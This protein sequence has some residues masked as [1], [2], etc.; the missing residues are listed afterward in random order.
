MKLPLVK[1]GLPIVLVY[2]GGSLVIPFLSVFLKD[3]HAAGDVLIGN[4]WAY[5][6]L[7]I[8]IGALLIPLLVERVGRR[9]VI[10]SAAVFSGF[11]ILVMG[12]SESRELV[13]AA[14]V[15]R[16]GIFN[17]AL[18]VYRAL[19]ID[20]APRREYTIAALTLALAENIGA[21]LGPPLSGRGQ[22]A[23]GY[24]PIF[25]ISAAIYALAAGLFIWSTNL[26]KTPEK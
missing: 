2:L 18:P 22:L 26:Q 4:T 5:I 6:Y 1:V 17:A 19:V 16:A 21:T 15:I 13:I 24:E 3:R 12:L 9:A 25:L 7:A 8:G 23:L 11:G 14:A 10:V 20:A